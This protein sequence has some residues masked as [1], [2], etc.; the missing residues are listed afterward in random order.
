MQVRLSG[1]LRERTGAPAPLPVAG[2]G[3]GAPD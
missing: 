1:G 2:S 3:A